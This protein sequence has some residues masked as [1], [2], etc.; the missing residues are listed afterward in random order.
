MRG[1]IQEFG[2]R[3]R[4][5]TVLLALL[6][7]QVG[8][9]VGPAHACGCGAMVVDPNAQFSVHRETAV[10]DWDGRTEQIVMRFT[11]DSDA[12]EAAWIMPVPGRAT[13]E[14]AD[15]A[16]FD[17]LVRIAA[18]V[19]RTRHYFWPR[20]GDWPF[21][22]GD[23]APGAAPGQGADGSGVGVVGRERLGDFDV[24][25]LTATDPDA[26][27]D[28][29]TANGF[30]MPDGLGEDLRPYVDQ[31]SEYV[32]VRLAPAEQGKVLDGTLDPLRLSF[33]SETLVYPMRLSRRATTA[34]SLGLFVL[35]QHRMEPRGA[36]G[37]SEPEVTYAGQIEP[38]GAVGRLTEEQDRF[39][40]V[41]DQRFP[42]PGRID[43]DH[44]LVPA[45]SDTPFQ[46]V[47]WD[48]DLLTVADVPV[49]LM[50]TGLPVLAVA[51]VVWRVRVRRRGA[52]PVAAPGT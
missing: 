18:P 28:W 24:A 32:A 19:H 12:P 50:A 15:A 40:T 49:W 1:N 46:R 9:L 36:I 29:L 47:V 7:L 27:G 48:D 2:S 30:T 25:R 5:L 3:A 6:M 21:D 26:L 42:D 8:S 34:Q 51:L 10:V 20:N 41:L 45:A 4:V 38:K 52:L 43:G 35:A 37:G 16:V 14:L 22:H 13:V 17:E 33:A 39:L 31:G 44:E 23:G 11:V